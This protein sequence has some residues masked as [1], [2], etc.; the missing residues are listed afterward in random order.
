MARDFLRQIPAYT[1]ATSEV[2]QNRRTEVV[3]W[4][5]GKNYKIPRGQTP[6]ILE[7]VRKVTSKN[8]SGATIHQDARTFRLAFLYLTD[9]KRKA[10][11]DTLMERSPNSPGLSGVKALKAAGISTWEQVSPKKAPAPT[12]SVPPI[13]TD[14]TQV[15]PPAEPPTVEIVIS[16]VLS[17]LS[18]AATEIDRTAKTLAELL[19]KIIQEKTGLASEKE[20]LARKVLEQE[21]QLAELGAKATSLKEAMGREHLRQLQRLAEEDEA[22]RPALLQL[23]EEIKQE[24]EERISKIDALKAR[25]PQR[26]EKQ[27][28]GTL[29][30][31]EPF[32]KELLKLKPFEQEQVIKALGLL[33]KQGWDYRAF[34]T[35]RYRQRVP[36]S[37]P[38]CMVSRASDELRFSW[39]HSDR[40]MVIYWVWRRG[41]S[42]TGQKER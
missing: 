23:A 40:R 10:R 21:R 19:P 24:L 22:R 27:G 7:H 31:E 9:Q 41:E 6:K 30:Y 32:L 26:Y 3:K 1:N 14:V 15:R 25:L 37:P 2:I 16:Q 38:R 11:I 5:S 13:I 4:L 34:Q 33:S 42:R 18:S 12:P 8:V 39:K 28:G 20:S 17:R 29:T 35:Q 36:S